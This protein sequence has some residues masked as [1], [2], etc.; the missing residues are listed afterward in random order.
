MVHYGVDEQAGFGEGEGGDVCK[1]AE[2]ED[3]GGFF[4]AEGFGAGAGGGEGVG[5]GHGG[6]DGEVGEGG[7]ERMGGEEGRM[8]E[9]MM[10]YV[11]K[12]ERELRNKIIHPHKLP[13]LVE[14]S[15]HRSELPFRATVMSI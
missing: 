9:W 1:F 4:V 12:C 10:C 14:I 7:G 2:V 15:V 5:V 3:G 13:P 6:E 8:E 11:Y